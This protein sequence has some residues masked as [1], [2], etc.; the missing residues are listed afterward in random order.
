MITHEQICEEGVL[1]IIRRR[2]PAKTGLGDI[3]SETLHR[4]KVG[5]AG[6]LL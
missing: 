6:L 1:L 3:S 5:I 2:G 4:G